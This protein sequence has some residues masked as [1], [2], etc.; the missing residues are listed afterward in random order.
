MLTIFH[1]NP[2]T[3]DMEL[4]AKHLMD[5]SNLVSKYFQFGGVLSVFVCSVDFSETT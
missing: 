2:F 1:Q 4:D 5:P 3:F